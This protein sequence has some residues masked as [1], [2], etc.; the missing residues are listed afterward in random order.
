MICGSLE[1]WK[2]ELGV[3]YLPHG[4]LSKD[5]AQMAGQVREGFSERNM[6]ESSTLVGSSFVFST[7]ELMERANY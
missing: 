2:D 1:H 5:Y 3:F 7:L 6:K 4:R